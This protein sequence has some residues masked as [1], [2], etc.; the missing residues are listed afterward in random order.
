MPRWQRSSRHN[1]L[2]AFRIFPSRSSAHVLP[3]SPPQRS[4]AMRPLLGWD[5]LPK[6]FPRLSTSCRAKKL[7]MRWMVRGERRLRFFKSRA[8][9]MP[10][11]VPPRPNSRRSR[12]PSAAYRATSAGGMNVRC[13]YFLGIGIADVS[14]EA[15]SAAQ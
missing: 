5:G 15:L 11:G 1:Y 9:A 12:S 14:I 13:W 3:G 7:H 6:S 4:H 8:R 2:S 10:T